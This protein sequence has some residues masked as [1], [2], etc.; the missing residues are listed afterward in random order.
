MSLWTLVSVVIGLGSTSTDAW[1]V[2]IVLAFLQSI[3]TAGSVQ[4]WTLHVAYWVFSIRLVLKQLSR[5]RLSATAL[6]VV[7]L[8]LKHNIGCLGCFKLAY[9]SPSWVVSLWWTEG[10]SVLLGRDWWH[11]AVP[12]M[13]Y[14][15]IKDEKLVLLAGQ[16]Y[17][18][19][20]SLSSACGWSTLHVLRVLLSRL[21]S[22]S[23]AGSWNEL[24]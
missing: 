5:L 23:W 13:I 6:L 10:S 11:L 2:Y 21:L 15:G 3:V 19:S 9:S 17:L 14:S 8:L 16:V 24:W 12:L 7:L 1:I 4:V 18:Q 22:I 20:W